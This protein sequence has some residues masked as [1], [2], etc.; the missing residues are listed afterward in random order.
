M[1]TSLP[2]TGVCARVVERADDSD[3]PEPATEVSAR[4]LVDYHLSSE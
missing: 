3:D 2:K 1:D 4:S